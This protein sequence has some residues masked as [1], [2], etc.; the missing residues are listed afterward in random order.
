MS[1]EKLPSNTN[2]NFVN[3]TIIYSRSPIY[4]KYSQ[5]RTI[6]IYTVKGRTQTYAT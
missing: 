6:I 1:K 2:F 5:N 3:V 4:I